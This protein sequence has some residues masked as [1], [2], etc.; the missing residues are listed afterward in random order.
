MKTPMEKLAIILA[1]AFF[2]SLLRQGAAQDEN[3]PCTLPGTNTTR[4]ARLLARG[5]E[6]FCCDLATVDF[7]CLCTSTNLPGILDP[8]TLI[9]MGR[10]CSYQLPD[11]CNNSLPTVN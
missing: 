9:N 3:L 11:V 6:I 2:C 1:V 7:A 10:S 8:G 4:C 5:F